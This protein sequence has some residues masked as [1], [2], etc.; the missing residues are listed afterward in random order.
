MDQA[1]QRKAAMKPIS[2]KVAVPNC[3]LF[4]RDSEIADIP[5]VDYGEERPDLVDTNLRGSDLPGG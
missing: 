2:L 1:Q 4:V 3:L 5:D